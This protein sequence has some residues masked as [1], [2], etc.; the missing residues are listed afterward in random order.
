MKVYFCTEL[1]CG[2]D[3]TKAQENAVAERSRASA[4]VKPG[5]VVFISKGP[6]SRR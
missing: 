6:R 3:A 4:L 5:G 1:E 2:T